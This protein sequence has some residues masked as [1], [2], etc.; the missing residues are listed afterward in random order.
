MKEIF[1]YRLVH[2]INNPCSITG[3]F[4][5][6]HRILCKY[7]L[8]CV[9]YSFISDGKFPSKQSWKTLVTRNIMNVETAKLQCATANEQSLYGFEVIHGEV[10]PC[11]IW[12][13]CKENWEHKNRS[14]T[15]M[16][17]L[18]RLFGLSYDKMCILCGLQTDSIAVHLIM[19]CRNNC[20]VR[21][22]LWNTLYLY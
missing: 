13:F 22:R 19:Y 21:T 7:G 16:D 11:P 18:S 10:R 5:D 6:I 4:P 14:I 1:V 2:Y 12:E 3:F 8:E 17:L 15:V 9:M 20:S